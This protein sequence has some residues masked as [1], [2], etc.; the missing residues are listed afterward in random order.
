MFFQSYSSYAGATIEEEKIVQT[1]EEVQ[2]IKYEAV[3]LDYV[4]F[5]FVE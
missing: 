4:S 1:P 3:S 2:A 5:K